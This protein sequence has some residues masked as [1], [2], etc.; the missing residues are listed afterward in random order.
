M[1]DKESSVNATRRDHPHEQPAAAGDD[2]GLLAISP[3]QG[4]LDAELAA[5]PRRAKPPGPTLYLSAGIL[6]VAGVAG[7]IQADKLWGG[8]TTSS[9]APAGLT[10]GGT[11]GQAGDPGV[12]GGPASGGSAGMTIGTVQR[13]DGQTLYLRTVNGQ[14]VKVTISGS[15]A[16]RVTKDG[17]LG[18]L[19]SGASIV[20]QGTPGA[21]GTVTA[22]SVS[23][24]GGGGRTGG[25]T[26]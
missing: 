25:G 1:I 6:L 2:S 12:P 5:R 19:K 17:A 23:E 9:A 20:V 11:R 10:A 8:T 26:P 7:G 22:T 18:D 21:N 14:V 3:F 16:V 24:G 13:I 4:D 15:T